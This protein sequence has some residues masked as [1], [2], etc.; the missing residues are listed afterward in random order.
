MPVEF[1]SGNFASP[2]RTRLDCRQVHPVTGAR[3]DQARAAHMHLADGV[4]HLLDRGYF[5]DGEPVRQKPL[6]DQLHHPLVSRVQ[7]DRPEML[8]TNLHRLL[9]L[10]LFLILIDGLSFPFSLKLAHSPRSLAPTLV[11]NASPAR[12]LLCLPRR[13]LGGGG[14]L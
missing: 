2:A 12:T 13:S 1:V 11:T 9:F 14:S 5:L 6:I 7:P 8:S 3:S 4:C 10:F